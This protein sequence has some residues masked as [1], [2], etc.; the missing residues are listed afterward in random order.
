ML[1]LGATPKEIAFQR[2]RSRSTIKNQLV[3]IRAKLTATTSIHAVYLAV[4]QGL[5]P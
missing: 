3:D 4:K 5:I 2:G 1:A